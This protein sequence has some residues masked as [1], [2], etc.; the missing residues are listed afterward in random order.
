VP[1]SKSVSTSASAPVISPLFCRKPASADLAARATRPTAAV[2]WNNSRRERVKS[3]AALPGNADIRRSRRMETGCALDEVWVSSAKREKSLEKKHVCQAR[4][5]E[6]LGQ[7]PIELA[8]SP[9]CLKRMARNQ[10]W[11]DVRPT[12]PTWPTSRGLAKLAKSPG[13]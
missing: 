1:L 12:W 7:I 8:K 4:R 9:Y 3:T 10:L 11:C 2:V 5:S 13:Q 6:R